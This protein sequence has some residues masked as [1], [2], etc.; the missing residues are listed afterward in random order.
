MR[1][2]NRLCTGHERATLRAALSHRQVNRPETKGPY[3]P[4]IFG[5]YGKHKNKTS[6]F[7]CRTL[8]THCHPRLA[9]MSAKRIRNRQRSAFCRSPILFELGLVWASGSRLATLFFI[10]HIRRWDPIQQH[11]FKPRRN[12][13][14]VDCEQEATAFRA[15]VFSCWLC[16]FW[17]QNCHA[18]RRGSGY[19]LL[20]RN[21]S[22]GR[23]VVS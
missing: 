21:I 13:F 18:V 14:H 2:S 19:R 22:H 3:H 12:M 9:T 16:V 7:P 5:P 11:R 20:C 23:L 17:P 1:L 4:L 6:A 10:V 8:A 15:V